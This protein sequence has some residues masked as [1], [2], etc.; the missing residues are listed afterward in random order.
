M[1]YSHRPPIPRVQQIAHHA[2]LPPPINASIATQADIYTMLG[3]AAHH[4]AS[5]TVIDVSNHRH[6]KSSCATY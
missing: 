2:T 6:I 1:V 5:R 4:L 3:P